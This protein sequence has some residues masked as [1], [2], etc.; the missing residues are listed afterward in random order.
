MLYRYKKIIDEHTTHYAEPSRDANGNADPTW[1]EH[2]TLDDGYTYV[3]CNVPVPSQEP[4]IEWAAVANND[5]INADVLAASVHVE[6]VAKR[7]SAGKFMRA[8]GHIVEGDDQ[9][10]ADWAGATVQAWSDPA[11]WHVNPVMTGDQRTLAGKLWVSLMDYN[12]WAPPI[13]WREVVDAG[14]PAWVQPTGAHDAYALGDRVEFNGKNYES[15]I[16]A[17]VW[18]PAVYPAGWV[19]V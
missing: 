14:Y 13:G 17:N 15:L 1:F 8:D 6:F 7:V 9:T 4:I 11:N 5:P 12:V 18:S 16:P 19:E 10:V 2:C 3:T